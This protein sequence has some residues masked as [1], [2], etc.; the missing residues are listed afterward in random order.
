M[1]KNNTFVAKIVK[2]TLDFYGHFCPRRKAANF[3]HPAG[4]S[5]FSIPFQSE[6]VSLH[7]MATEVK[8]CHR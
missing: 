5:I 2:K 7:T 8:L 1:R 3:F 6:P 4:G